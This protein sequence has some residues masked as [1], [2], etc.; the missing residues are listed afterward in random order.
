[1]DTTDANLG[2]ASWNATPLNGSTPAPPG[3]R[4]ES[5]AQIEIVVQAVILALAVLGN[6][7]V[8]LVLACR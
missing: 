8:L 5:L 2:T 7:F 4:D 6:S 1:M 3:G